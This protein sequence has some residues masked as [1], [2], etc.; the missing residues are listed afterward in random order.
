[1]KYIYILILYRAIFPIH[2]SIQRA[3]TVL[4]QPNCCGLSLVHWTNKLEGGFRVALSSTSVLMV[5]WAHQNVCSQWLLICSQ[6][7]LQW[8]PASLGGSP[9]SADGSDPGFFRITASSLGPGMCDILCAPCKSGDF[10]SQSP[11]ALLILSPAG[12][13]SHTFLGCVFLV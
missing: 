3:Q 13:Q 11:L 6:D 1:M 7:E 12:L 5:E 2:C 10:I 9:R 4:R 8:S